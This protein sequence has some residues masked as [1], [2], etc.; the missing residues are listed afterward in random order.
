MEKGV[1][2]SKVD[3]ILHKFGK[4]ASRMVAI[5]SIYLVA[6]DTNM[7]CSLIK[8]IFVFFNL[9]IYNLLIVLH[10]SPSRDCVKNNWHYKLKKIK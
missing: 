2:G 4:I 9:T 6:M 10:L 8:L 5:F 3:M 7:E 1:E